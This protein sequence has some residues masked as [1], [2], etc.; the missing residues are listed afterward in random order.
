MSKTKPS[1]RSG[2]LDGHTHFALQQH[3]NEEQQESAAI[4]DRNGQKVEDR[5]I[6]TDERP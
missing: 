6:E 4:Q 5:Q 2:F 3:F 1:L